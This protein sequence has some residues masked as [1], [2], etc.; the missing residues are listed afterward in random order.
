MAAM[1]MYSSAPC[2]IIK[3]TKE[4]GGNTGMDRGRERRRKGRR[5][6]RVKEGR[7]NCLTN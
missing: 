3:Q 7:G 5:G 4:V 2:K 1:E 6:G